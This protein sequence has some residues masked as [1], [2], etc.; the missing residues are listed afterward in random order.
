MAPIFSL[1]QEQDYYYGKTEKS[2]LKSSAARLK[3]TVS[4]LCNLRISRRLRGE[5]K[6]SNDTGE[7]NLNKFYLTQ[8]I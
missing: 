1:Y 8:Y 7:I 5:K 3:Y 6:K 2:T 4:H